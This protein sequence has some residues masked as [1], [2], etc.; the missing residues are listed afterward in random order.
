VSRPTDPVG[1]PPTAGVSAPAA[2]PVEADV[3][4]AAVLAC[5]A[6]VSLHAGGG[7]RQVATYLP[8]RRVAGVRADERSVEVSVVAAA[9]VALP[10]VAAQVRSALAPLAGLRAVDVHI[11]DVALPEAGAAATPSVASGPV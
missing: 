11:A 4:A 1:P 10:D 2:S 5:P 3:I 9:G 7:M 8:G 6:V